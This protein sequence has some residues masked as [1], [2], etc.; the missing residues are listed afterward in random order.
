MHSAVRALHLMSA[1]PAQAAQVA[2]HADAVVVGSAIVDL[3]GEAA[4]RQSNDIPG[5]VERFVAALAAAVHGARLES[6]A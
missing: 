3:V 6:A 4:A 2:R 1:D 5:E